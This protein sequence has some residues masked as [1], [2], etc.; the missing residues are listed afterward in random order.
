MYINKYIQIKIDIKKRTKL[1]PVTNLLIFVS[2]L[3]SFSGTKAVIISDS[4]TRT[5]NPIGYIDVLTRPGATPQ[6]LL[7]FLEQNPKLLH[8]YKIVV[9]HVGTTWLSTKNERLLY[10]RLVNGHIDR[11]EYNEALSSMNP[12]P[13]IGQAIVFRD[14]YKNLIDFIKTV[15][16]E[17]IILVSAI[18]PRPWDH[19]RRNLVRKSYNNLLQKFNSNS[20]NVY[21]IPTY[22]LFFDKSKNLKQDLF[23]GDGIHLAERGSIVL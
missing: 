20:N 18:I 19:G 21:F 22:K 9:L 11:K 23:N 8:N 2:L 1:A 4:L 13:A 3:L 5:L 6:K 16:P 10:L 15:N 17:T 7:H 12:P 14:Q